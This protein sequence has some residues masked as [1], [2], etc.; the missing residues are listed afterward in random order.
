[1]N[2]ISERMIPRPRNAPSRPRPRTSDRLADAAPPAAPPPQVGDGKS[3]RHDGWTPERQ[4]IFL[5]ALGECGVVEDAARA[6]GMSKQSAYAFR[7]RAAGR[8]FHL[9]WLA[10]QQQARHLLADALMS[11][12]LHGCVELIYRDGKLWGERHRF[13]NRLT[14][15]LH[16]RLKEEVRE[17]GGDDY[18]PAHYIA[19]EFDEYLDTLSSGEEGAV[20]DFVEGRQA[21]DR[22]AASKEGRLLRRLDRYQAEGSGLDPE[23]QRDDG[24]ADALEQLVRAALQQDEVEGEEFDEEELEGEE[25][26]SPAED[27]Q[28]GANEWQPSTS[29]TSPPSGRA[30]DRPLTAPDPSERAAADAQ[31]GPARTPRRRPPDLGPGGWTR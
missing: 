11:R 3:P 21:A 7:N 10:A 4:R 16:T 19:E 15:A 25:A 1:M 28:A 31:E 30:N 8:G 9:G 6:A 20:A 17:R 22:Y 29:S 12:A 23:A 5:E 14:L 24:G 27:Q 2:K 18:R 13:D 26:P